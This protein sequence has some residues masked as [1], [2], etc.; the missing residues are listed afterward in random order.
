MESSWE[1]P[2]KVVFPT[3]LILEAKFCGYDVEYKF[4]H[5][6]LEILEP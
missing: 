6:Q 3:E 1:I 2:T 5:Q 4:M